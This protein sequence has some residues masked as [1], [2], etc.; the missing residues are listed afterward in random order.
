MNN[1]PWANI[2]LHRDKATVYAL[3]EDDKLNLVNRFSAQ[4]QSA[5][6][7]GATDEECIEVA[8]LFQAAPDLAEALVATFHELGFMMSPELRELVGKALTKAHGYEVEDDR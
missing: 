5:G 4:V 2:P 6:P 8:T 3:T 1:K 7:H